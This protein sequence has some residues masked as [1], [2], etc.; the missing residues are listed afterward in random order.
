[1][2]SF[3]FGSL[4]LTY[5]TKVI[6]RF[7]DKYLHLLNH[8]TGPHILQLS[9]LLPICSNC[10]FLVFMLDSEPPGST[11]NFHVDWLILSL[12]DTP[13]SSPTLL[14]MKSLWLAD[15]ERD[16]VLNQQRDLLESSGVGMDVWRQGAWLCGRP[17][18]VRQST[19]GRNESLHV[20]LGEWCQGWSR[21]QSLVVDMNRSNKPFI[22]G[23]GNKA[24]VGLPRVC[25]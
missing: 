7:G 6:I 24:E 17:W 21:E 1:M 5:G 15:T 16:D 10:F 12:P 25:G 11:V 2:I 22:P 3:Q 18:F 4:L 23:L 13:L 20:S 19:K 9:S 8:L 14:R